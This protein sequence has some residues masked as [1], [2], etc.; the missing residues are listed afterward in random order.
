LG[1]CHFIP[2]ETTFSIYFLNDDRNW[3]EKWNEF[4]ETIRSLGYPSFNYVIDDE[5]KPKWLSL[6]QECRKNFGIEYMRIYNEL[7]NPLD[8]ELL[9]F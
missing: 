8:L 1:L 4:I 9:T 5:R 7:I 6:H 2:L 3:T